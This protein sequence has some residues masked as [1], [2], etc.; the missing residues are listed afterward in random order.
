MRALWGGSFALLFVTAGTAAGAVTL[1]GSPSHGHATATSLTI[2]HTT[3][4][5]YLAVAVFNHETYPDNTTATYNGVPMDR[6]NSAGPIG[7]AEELIWFGMVAPPSGTH[8]IVITDDGKSTSYYAI[9]QS[10]N[11]VHQ[12]RPFLQGG[13]YYAPFFTAP[14]SYTVPSAA[15]WIVLDALW[16]DANFG[17]SIAPSGSG[18]NALVDFDHNG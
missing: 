10:F 7:G 3:S 2:S 6:I 15:G 11:G 1:A 16:T 12:T 13:G 9:A 17:G 8:D 14:Y 5:D 18:D 4:G